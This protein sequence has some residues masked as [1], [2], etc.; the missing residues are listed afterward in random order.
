MSK[1]AVIALKEGGMTS[2]IV[3][4]IIEI[5]ADAAIGLQLPNNHI[6][7]DCGQYPV[8]IGDEWNDGFFTREG[9]PIEPVPTA[10]DKIAILDSQ[11]TDTQ[12]ALCEQYEENLK[13]QEEVTNTQLALCELY[14]SII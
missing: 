3:D 14:E 12:M 1:K 2:G 5:T 10:E 6:L 11:L 7:W 13:L 8:T 4:N 9:E